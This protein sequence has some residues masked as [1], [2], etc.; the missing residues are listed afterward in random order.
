MDLAND[1]RAQEALDES[2]CL[3]DA[4]FASAKGGG[5]EIG[6]TKRGKGL[7][8]MA[9][10]VRYGLPLSV[11]THMANHHEVN[12]V[13]LSFDFNMIEQRRTD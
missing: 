12:L 11:S 8:I 5:E 6:K 13:K 4:I 3:I 7:K 10:V 2:E 9:I 1:L